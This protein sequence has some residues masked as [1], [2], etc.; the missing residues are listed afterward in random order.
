[1]ERSV[2]RCHSPIAMLVLVVYAGVFGYLAYEHVRYPGFTEAMEGDVLQHIER[3]TQGLPL[4][5]EPGGEYI[6]LAYM[7]LYYVMAAPFYL[8]FGDSFLGPRL[9]SS[10]CASLACVLVGWIGYR[11][12]RDRVAALLSAA[13]FLA[14]YRVMDAYLT[15]AMPDSLLLLWLLLGY[16]FFA[17]GT[18]RLHDCIW[19]VC[20]TLAFWTKQHGAFFFGFA[21]M[22]A[23]LFRKNAL[24]RW[25]LVLGLLVGGP[26]AYVVIGSQLGERFFYH[27]FIVPRRWDHNG[28]FALRR[29]VFLLV[30]FAPIATLLTWH[31]LKQVVNWR[32]RQVPPLA[33]FVVTTLIS[34]L[35]TMSSAGSSNNHYIPLLAIMSVSAMLGLKRVLQEG[36]SGQ[37]VLAAV[38]LTVFSVAAA[39]VARQQFSNHD[40]PLVAP[41]ALAAVTLGVVLCWLLRV[42]VTAVVGLLLV[43][44]FAVTSFYPPD[45]LPPSEFVQG[46]AQLRTEL[47]QLDG[48]VIW[49]PYGNVP[50][51]LTGVK[52]ARA[53]SWVA[54]EDI[55]RQRDTGG[56]S[57]ADLEPFRKRI[58]SAERLYVLSHDPIRHVPVWSSLEGNLELVR[59]FDRQLVGLAEVTSH[60][61]SGRSYPRFLYRLRPNAVLGNLAAN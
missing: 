4:Y 26:L 46:M 29:S 44:Q 18:T 61:Y 28:W 55:E 38:G 33:W 35:I 37:L 51:A 24:P 2:V 23:L 47:R 54:L 58:Q 25:V 40:V 21:V 43:G 6:A 56:Q 41:I 39:W 22:Y 31:A 42:N 20:F 57:A 14:G 8:S 11:E 17:Y 13:V 45:Y 36:L 27:T 48:P 34:T 3:I 7:P 1:M 10:F 12:S 53:P 59:D 52:L 30:C 15:C 32:S 19:L 50:S 60:W 16:C 9:L 49:V 5:P